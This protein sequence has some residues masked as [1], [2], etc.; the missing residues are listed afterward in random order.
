M[1]KSFTL[2]GPAG[3]YLSDAPGLLGGYRPKKIYGSLECQ[4]AKRA[5]ARGSYVRHRVF[6]ADEAA[7]QACGYR[8]CAKCLPRAYRDWK[9]EQSA[10]PTEESQSWKIEAAFPPVFRST[11]FA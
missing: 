11:H 1:N 2:L 10:S 8:P 4:S 5:I 3:P 7:A 9:Q 6:F